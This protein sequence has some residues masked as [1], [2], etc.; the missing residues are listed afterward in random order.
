MTCFFCSS[1]V[2]YFKKYISD[3]T[4]NFYP[5][6]EHIASSSFRLAIVSCAD[7]PGEKRTRKRRNGIS[8]KKRDT[9][10]HRRL[11]D[12]SRTGSR[13]ASNHPP[14]STACLSGHALVSRWI[15]GIETCLT[16]FKTE[17]SSLVYTF[18]HY[19][20]FWIMIDA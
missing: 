15:L 1:I 13:R 3:F 11:V 10:I 6:F 16:E 8:D 18:L 14:P 9:W 17:W 19:I 12:V 4:S 5:L 20:N 7:V 2:C